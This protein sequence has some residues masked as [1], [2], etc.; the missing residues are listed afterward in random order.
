MCGAM[1]D[2][3]ARAFAASVRI[4]PCAIRQRPGFHQGWSLSGERAV[5][6]SSGVASDSAAG[7]RVRQTP[8]S[9]TLPSVTFMLR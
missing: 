4:T 1:V 7:G 5:P 3:H 2:N 6:G 8:A 9:A